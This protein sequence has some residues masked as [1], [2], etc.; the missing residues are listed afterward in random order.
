MRITYTGALKQSERELE[1]LRIC[2]GKYVAMVCNKSCGSF[3]NSGQ[4]WFV[5]PANHDLKNE[6]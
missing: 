1:L 3:V 5:F 4:L 6:T 2:V